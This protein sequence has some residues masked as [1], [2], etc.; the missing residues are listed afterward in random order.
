MSRVAG[1]E[2]TLMI[3]KTTVLPLNYT[4]SKSLNKRDF[5]PLWLH[6]PGIKVYAFCIN[7]RVLQQQFCNTLILKFIK[8]LLQFSLTATNL[9]SVDIF[10]IANKMFLFTNS[11]NIFKF[12]ILAYSKLIKTIEFLI[13]ILL[14]IKASP[15]CGDSYFIYCI[16]LHLNTPKTF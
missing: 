7:L 11:V 10:K 3:L 1:I 16:L 12:L 15:Q 5:Y 8:R 14:N 4:P 2:P 6:F 13:H 9:N